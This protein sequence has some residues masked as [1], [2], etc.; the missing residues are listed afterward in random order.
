MK[1]K[2]KIKHYSSK[3]D[4]NS[5][6][7]PKPQ[8]K[9]INDQELKKIKVIGLENNLKKEATLK[10][11]FKKEFTKEKNTHH[12]YPMWAKIGV[13]TLVMAL[14]GGGFYGYQY[15]QQNYSQQ[16]TGR[17]LT[18]AQQASFVRLM[19]NYMKANWRPQEMNTAIQKKYNNFSKANQEQLAY[20]LYRSQQNSALYY[21]SFMYFM[22][23]E[24]SYYN[25]NGLENPLKAT[26]K[27]LHNKTIPATF[28]DIRT[29]HEFMEYTGVD[30]VEVLPDFEW[31]NKNYKTRADFK[32]FLDI[33]QQENQDPIFQNRKL[34]VKTA[35]NR[36]NRI[37]LWLSYYPTSD[38]KQD[39]MSLAKFYYEA[40]FQLN[41]DFGVTKKGQ[42]YVIKENVYK[43]LQAITNKKKPFYRDLH[44]FLVSLK[45][46]HTMTSALRTSYQTIAS[47]Y[48]GDSVYDN[49]ADAVG[50]APKVSSKDTP[51]E[52]NKTQRSKKPFEVK[53]NSAEKKA[54]QENKLRQ[55]EDA[56]K[57]KVNK[58]IANQEGDSEA[59]IKK[60]QKKWNSFSKKKKER[61]E[62][63][64]R[65]QE[66]Y[67]VKKNAEKNK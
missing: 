33:A 50:G 18:P 17:G 62:K 15:Y 67:Q 9:R 13:A 6:I 35:Y 4:D 64:M 54:E 3:K 20:I 28:D 16:A 46:N 22:Q 53:T 1:N 14:A 37:L 5:D 63:E 66:N 40:I 47:S 51:S 7:K 32:A 58:K 24:F 41:N 55:K 43:E 29:N 52:Y 19:R 44:A 39:A 34:N 31:L 56:A 49:L 10:E 11:E 27:Q 38:F 57:E 23:A 30:N 60:A 36:L 45:K 2:D 25:L 65:E 48:F 59:T 8:K 26:P 42:D 61:L 12:T 21:N